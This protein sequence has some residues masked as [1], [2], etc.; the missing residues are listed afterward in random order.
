MANSIEAYRHDGFIVSRR[1]CDT[2]RRGFLQAVYGQLD[3][4]PVQAWLSGLI[5][6]ILRMVYAERIQVTWAKRRDS[7]SEIRRQPRPPS[8]VSSE[9]VP[10]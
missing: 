9:P 4:S 1:L 6:L 8:T 10:R 2:R 7:A 3:E 5:G